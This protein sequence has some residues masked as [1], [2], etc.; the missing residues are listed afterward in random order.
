[1]LTDM[2]ELFCERCGTIWPVVERAPCVV[3]CALCKLQKR[4]E[5][6]FFIFFNFEACSFINLEFTSV[7][8]S[9]FV[10]LIGRF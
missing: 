3:T 5:G 1:M 6:I 7:P 9:F 4:I 8:A 2:D 10:D